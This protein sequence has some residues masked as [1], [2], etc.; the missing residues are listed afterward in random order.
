M[1]NNCKKVICRPVIKHIHRNTCIYIEE[2]FRKTIQLLCDPDNTIDVILQQARTHSDIESSASFNANQI[3]MAL[4]EDGAM[5]GYQ[6]LGVF[7]SIAHTR[8]YCVWTD[9]AVGYYYVNSTILELNKFFKHAE[10]I[11]YDSM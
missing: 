10:S 11:K 1:I 5:Q 4:H 8:E 9:V 7:Y 2:Y 3:I 6:P